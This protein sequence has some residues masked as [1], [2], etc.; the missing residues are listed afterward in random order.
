MAAE[1]LTR[2]DRAQKVQIEH[3]AQR[4]FRQIEEAQV[5]TGGGLRVVAAGAVDQSVDAPEFV[6][7]GAR[8]VP[9]RLLFERVADDDHSASR[10]GDPSSAAA[11][12]SRFRARIAT[13]APHPTSAF[14]IAPHRT[15]VAPVT[16]IVR[17]VKSYI[18]NNAFKSI[19]SPL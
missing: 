17:P 11:P 19:L 13:L 16:T 4:V 1:D 7:R 12:F 5:L 6:E 15:P 9:Q 14:A 2:Q 10:A 3:V 18:F 8:G